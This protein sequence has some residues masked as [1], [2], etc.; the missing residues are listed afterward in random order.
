M[1]V[2]VEPLFI[3]GMT[4]L[5]KKEKQK[6]KLVIMKNGLIIKTGVLKSIFIRIC[7]IYFVQVFI[8]VFPNWKEVH[9][10]S[11]IALCMTHI[12]NAI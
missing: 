6:E 1:L 9:C 11:S 7:V 12:I 4:K 5:K 3:V 2:F 10:S 8:L